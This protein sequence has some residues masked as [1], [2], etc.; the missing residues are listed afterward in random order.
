MSIGKS[1]A[2]RMGEMI[3]AEPQPPAIY[4][5]PVFRLAVKPV[6]FLKHF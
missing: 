2:G 1:S 3:R 6:I 4:P 5:K